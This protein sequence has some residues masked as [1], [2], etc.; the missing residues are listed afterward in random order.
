[1]GHMWISSEFPS[2]GLPSSEVRF[3]VVGR[4][5]ILDLENFEFLDLG[6]GDKW[7]RI[8]TPERFDYLKEPKSPIRLYPAHRRRPGVRGQH[9]RA[10]AAAGRRR[11]GAGGG[12]D[13]RGVPALGAD[14]AGGRPA[15]GTVRGA[16][17]LPTH[18]IPSACTRARRRAASSRT[19]MPV[20]LDLR[21]QTRNLGLFAACTGLIYL[22]APVLYVGVTQASLCHR[23]GASDTVANLP[24]TAYLAMTCAPV[25]VAWLSPYVSTLRRNLVAC[26]AA[27]AAILAVDGGGARCRRCRRG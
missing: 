10:A 16:G 5:G 1:M 18:D 27:V 22:C 6:K 13:L 9:P 11:G 14:R 19:S 21:D 25:L 12:G 8:Y 23:L 3:Q 2:P 17:C 4:D 20:P 26:F 7:E 24:A 15:V